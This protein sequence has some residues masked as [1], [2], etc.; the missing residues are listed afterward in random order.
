MKEVSDQEI[1]EEY[2]E[3]IQHQT[4]YSRDTVHMAIRIGLR[5]ARQRLS[6]CLEAHKT[7]SNQEPPSTIL[8]LGCGNP[9]ITKTFITN[10]IEHTNTGHFSQELLQQHSQGDPLD[11]RFQPWF[12]RLAHH[13]GIKTVG[14]DI[15]E[16]PG[17]EWQFIQ[18]DL[19]RKALATLLGDQRFDIIHASQFIGESDP[20]CNSPTFDVVNGPITEYNIISAARRSLTKTGVI[21][22]GDQY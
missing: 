21:L 11:I 3:T 14:I 6:Q 16:N 5:F 4:G 8:D 12:C 7:A 20:V 2:S 9:N 17:E 22:I 1:I 10:V 13:M 15:A 19:S 18:A